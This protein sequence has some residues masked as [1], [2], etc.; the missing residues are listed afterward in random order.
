[1]T[2]ADVQVDGEIIPEAAL[3]PLREQAGNGYIRGQEYQISISLD[4]TILIEFESGT[5]GYPLSELVQ[6]A[7]EQI[8]PEQ[9]GDRR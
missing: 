4:G 3:K 6:D 1:M 8:Y 5:V 7:H 9:A 2:D